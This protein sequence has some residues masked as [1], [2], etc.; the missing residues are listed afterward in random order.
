[1]EGLWMPVYVFEGNK[2]IIIGNPCYETEVEAKSKGIADGIELMAKAEVGCL[3][4]EA[5]C[6]PFSED[7][8]DWMLNCHIELDT[9]PS[10][11]IAVFAGPDYDKEF[12]DEK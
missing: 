12:E 11:E 6:I 5:Y 9:E 10:F 8:A 2:F 3:S 4:N 1:M 7:D